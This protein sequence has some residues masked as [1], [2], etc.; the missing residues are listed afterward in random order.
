MGESVDI[1]DIVVVPLD[2]DVASFTPLVPQRGLGSDP[3]P[4]DEPPSPPPIPV[5]PPYLSN[6]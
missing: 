3:D 5:Q 4:E 2:A 1:A 6:G